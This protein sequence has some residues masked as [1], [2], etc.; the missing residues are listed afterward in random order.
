MGQTGSNFFGSLISEPSWID[1][2]S[3]Q[4]MMDRVELGRITHFD[5]SNN[6]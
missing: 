6:C 4:P 1:S 3:D 5:N 2:L